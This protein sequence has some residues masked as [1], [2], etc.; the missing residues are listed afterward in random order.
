MPAA[1]TA[2][3]K[4]T[5]PET[6][7]LALGV[8]GT[9]GTPAANACLGEAD[10]VVVVVS[11][12]SPSDTAWENTKLLEPTRQ[13][14]VQIAIEPRHASWNFPAETVVLGDAAQILGELCE[15]VRS[16]SGARREK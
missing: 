13:D 11:K 4:G 5:F 16:R 7:P 12:L 3:G 10:L 6:H 8:F 2:A 9:F 1:T 15:A 14:F